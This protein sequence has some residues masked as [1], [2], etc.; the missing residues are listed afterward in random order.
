MVR[1]LRIAASV[2]FAIVTVGLLLMW[3]SSYLWMTQ[4]YG[5]CP[6]PRMFH[7]GSMCGQLTIRVYKYHGGSRFPYSWQPGGE[8]VAEIMDREKTTPPDMRDLL[9]Y[10]FDRNHGVLRDG[11]YFPHWWAVSVTGIA[12]IIFAAPVFRR[13][14][15]RAMFIATTLVAA[16]LGLIVWASR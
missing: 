10:R 8:S 2:F 5:Y 4:V 1:R 11:V 13:F 14:S 12:T 7:F 15:L 3:A 6:E 16:M 9:V